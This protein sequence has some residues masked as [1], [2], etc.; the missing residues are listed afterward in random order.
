MWSCQVRSLCSSIGDTWNRT[1]TFWARKNLRGRGQLLH[2]Q[3]QGHRK[4]WNTGKLRRPPRQGQHH[5]QRSGPRG[6]SSSRRSQDVL[7]LAKGRRLDDAPAGPVDTHLLSRGGQSGQQAE[8][9][10]GGRYHRGKQGSRRSQQETHRSSRLYQQETH[11]IPQ[12]TH[13]LDSPNPFS[14]D[15]RKEDARMSKRI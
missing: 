5:L 10:T 1:R 7:V 9:G 6:G 11:R 14:N 12:P 2:V 8:L 4:L 15:K 3:V 13:R